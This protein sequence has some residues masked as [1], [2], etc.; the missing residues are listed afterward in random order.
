MQRHGIVAFP[1]SI[2]SIVAKRKLR[3]PLFCEYTQTSK[4]LEVMNESFRHANNDIEQC[5][6]HCCS[7]ASFLINQRLQNFMNIS[8]SE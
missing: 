3:I 2:V 6:K 1:H 5:H 7:Y 4:K 8:F